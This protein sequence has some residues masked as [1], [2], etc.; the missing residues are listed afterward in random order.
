[1]ITEQDRKECRKVQLHML[2]ELRNICDRH[3]LIFWLDFGTL[4]GAHMHKSFIP[5][6]DDID[7]SMPMEDYKKFLA[8]AEKELP[9]DIF[10][11][12]HD[13][14][15]AYKECFAKLRDC[16]STFLEHHETGN[17][18]YH[19]GVYI[20]IFPWVVYPKMPR[21][22][23][24]VLLF[25]TVRSRG[26]AVS[27]NQ[28]F[29]FNYSIYL[30]CKFVWLL[31]SPFKSDFWGRTPEDNGYYE[32]VPQSVLFPLGEI[33]FEGKIY[34]SPGKVH[35]HLTIL[36]GAYTPDPPM[37]TRVSHARTI[38][39]NAPCNHPRAMKKE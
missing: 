27:R 8:I 34:P 14:D 20:D 38:L 26:K 15:K 13:T 19:H 7:V 6:D 2:D 39:L 23:K 5:W 33:E 25:F 9:R 3:G 32:A 16:H 18:N 11:Q 21:F 28:H 17:E 4:L 35:E 37:E 29:V 31:F 22:F 24:K 1:M 10:L 12:T 30:L 36:Y